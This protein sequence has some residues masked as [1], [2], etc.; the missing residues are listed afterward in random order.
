MEIT[1][2]EATNGKAQRYGEQQ[3]EKAQ[4]CTGQQM[5]NYDNTWGKK[6]EIATIHDVTNGKSHQYTGQQME[7]YSSTWGNKREIRQYCTWSNKWEITV[8][9]GETNVKLRQYMGQ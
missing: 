4:Q 6:W 5:G 2:Q 9:H 8:I 1:I 3:M 7:N